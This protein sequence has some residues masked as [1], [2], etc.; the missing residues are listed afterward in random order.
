LTCT[1]YVIKMYIM[2][3]RRRARRWSVADARANLPKVLAGAAREP[4]AVYRRTEPV[5]VVVSPRAFEALDAARHARE[6]ETL[7]DA[8]A[9]LRRLGGALRPPRRRDRPNRFARRR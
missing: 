6:S 2:K 4:Q 8:F 3:E 7:A 9:E 1:F 5:A